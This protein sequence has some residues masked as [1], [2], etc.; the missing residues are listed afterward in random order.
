M[1]TYLRILKSKKE[2]IFCIL[3]ILLSVAAC[4]KTIWISLDIDESYAIAVGY[5]LTK[6]DL[7]F[8]DLWESHQLS[9]VYLAPFIWLFLQIT[10]STTYVV[11]FTRILGTVF[12]LLIGVFLYRTIRSI[13][14][15]WAAWMLFFLHMNFLP[16]WVQTPEFELIQ[17]WFILLQFLCLIRAFQMMECDGWSDRYSK[18]IRRHNGL[19]AVAGFLVTA[20][21][22]LYPTLFMLYPV[23]VIG[24]AV[25]W[26]GKRNNGAWKDCI[27]F[28]LGAVIPGILFLIYLFQY[29]SL[30]ELMTYISYIRQDESHTLVSTA[31]KWE[32]YASD[33]G[34]IMVKILGAFAVSFLI[35]VYL[36]IRRFAQAG[37]L[38]RQSRQEAD[39]ELKRIEF[40]EMIQR[41]HERSILLG[42]AILILLLS[43]LHL[44]GCL[45]GNENQFYML[46]R[47]FAFTICGIIVFIYRHDEWNTRLFWFGIMPGIVTVFAVLT[48][49]NMDVNT[50]MAKM[51]ISVFAGI[52][53]LLT[54]KPEKE[55]IEILF[56]AAIVGMLLCLFVGK[57]IQMRITGCG[58]ITVAAPM[59]QI[60]KGPAK[61]IYMIQDTAAILNEDY[62]VLTESVT[63]KDKL[64]Y[65]GSENLVY[66][67]TDAVLATPSTQGTNAYNQ[68]FVTYYKVHPEKKP[69]VIVVDQELGTNPVYYNSPQNSILFRWIEKNYKAMPKLE[70]EHLK[71]YR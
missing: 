51:Y 56:Q 21:M 44:W 37:I 35:P 50:T 59:E 16:K 7:L 65:V 42:S 64:L 26:R 15:S 9:G 32:I 20:Q 70:T 31:V 18:V 46:W 60:Q 47:Y 14:P 38:G 41:E 8:R 67:W 4:L 30:S 71:F 28:T 19:I 63:A 17:Y 45:F 53:L 40:A 49:T 68:E 43:V 58:Q 55:W 1:G 69:T 27:I 39:N 24:I 48:I 13:I 33:F 34:T 62:D 11:I 22:M 10:G 61:G 3:F 29:M 2:R 12:H 36:M 6:G 54:L 25:C 52:L 23:Y 66:L 57:L 5:R